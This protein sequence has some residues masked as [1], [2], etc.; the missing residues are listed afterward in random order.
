VL[1]AALDRVELFSSLLLALIAQ[2][3]VSG[4]TLRAFRPLRF[5]ES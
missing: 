1:A 3:A 2:L 5:S 4:F